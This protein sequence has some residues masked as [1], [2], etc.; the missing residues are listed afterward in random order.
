MP[1]PLFT[2]RMKTFEAIALQPL[3][4]QHGRQ[5]AAGGQMAFMRETTEWHVA[6]ESRAPCGFIEPKEG[7]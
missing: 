7:K 4:V 6:H 3:L 5:T 1:G 2:Q